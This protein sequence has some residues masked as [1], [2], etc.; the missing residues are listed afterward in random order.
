MIKING[1]T[2]KGNNLHISSKGTFIDGVNILDCATVNKKSV[3]YLQK[4][5]NFLKAWYNIDVFTIKKLTG[6]DIKTLMEKFI[7]DYND[8]LTRLM[9]SNY[10]DG[11][12]MCSGVNNTPEDIDKGILVCWYDGIEYKMIPIG[13]GE[14]KFVTRMISYVG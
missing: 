12:I 7:G 1:K 13:K 14:V 4:F 11:K 9:I 6:D 10:G 5:F 8:N 2:Y 3:G